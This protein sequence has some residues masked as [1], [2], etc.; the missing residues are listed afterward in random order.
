VPSPIYKGGARHHWIIPLS[1]KIALDEYPLGIDLRLFYHNKKEGGV[2]DHD[3]RSLNEF[4]T[5]AIEVMVEEMRKIRET[6]SRIDAIR[7]F[8]ARHDYSLYLCKDVL[9]LAEGRDK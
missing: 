4:Q 2:M 8:R 7:E 3:F 1:H 5:I 6:H 9:N